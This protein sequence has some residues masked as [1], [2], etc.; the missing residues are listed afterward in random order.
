MSGR[1]A[2]ARGTLY[3]DGEKLT[4]FVVRRPLLDSK[5][6]CAVLSRTMRAMSV[7]IGYWLQ[8]PVDDAKLGEY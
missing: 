3:Q 7:D 4:S 5:G 6:S 2:T 1:G 8:Q